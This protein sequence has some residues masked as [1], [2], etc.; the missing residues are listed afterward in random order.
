[1]KNQFRLDYYDLLAKQ[2]KS[3]YLRFYLSKQ[4]LIIHRFW[5]YTEYIAVTFY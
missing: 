5:E 4:H 3:L 2:A 1:M